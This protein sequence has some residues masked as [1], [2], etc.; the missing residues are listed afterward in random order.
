MDK[1]IFTISTAARLYIAII[2]KCNCSLH[3]SNILTINY[4]MF[5]VYLYFI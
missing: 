3:D 2:Q 5:Y 4:L 1:Q